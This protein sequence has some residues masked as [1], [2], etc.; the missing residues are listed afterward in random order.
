MTTWWFQMRLRLLGRRV[1]VPIS[2]C[3]H[4]GAFRYGRDERHPYESYVRRLARDG[5]RRAARDELIE[6]LRHYRPETFGD[7]VGVTLKGRHGLWHFPWSKH[8]PEN[9]GWFEDPLGYPDIVTQF[10]AEGILWFRIEQEFF[11][12]ERAFYSI[13]RHGY[14]PGGVGG[15]IGWRFRRADGE[16]AFLL[17]DGNHRVSALAALGHATVELMYFPRATVRETEAARWPQV[18]SGLFSAADARNVFNAYFEGNAK[19]RTTEVA[20]RLLECPE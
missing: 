15:V 19:V 1:T 18:A 11:W 17:L 2:R 12:L 16:E 7:A 6:F 9:N 10:C 13:R 3:V 14:K 5:N 20:A 8:L 4:Y